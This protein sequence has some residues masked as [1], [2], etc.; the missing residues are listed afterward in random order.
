[1]SQRTQNICLSKIEVLMRIRQGFRYGNV[2]LAFYSVARRNRRKHRKVGRE[3]SISLTALQRSHGNR[4]DHHGNEHD[5][6][7]DRIVVATV[8]IA[9]V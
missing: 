2:I 8:A 4:R 3:T 5:Y 1:M 7:G 6:D 9:T